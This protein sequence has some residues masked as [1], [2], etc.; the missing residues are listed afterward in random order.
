MDFSSTAF[1]TPAPKVSSDTMSHTNLVMS[2][3]W[4]WTST[5]DASTPSTPLQTRPL[6][7]ATS[8]PTPDSA[9]NH[10][11]TKRF[12][13]C[14]GRLYHQLLCSHRIR[15]DLVE[16]CGANCVEPYGSAI[17]VA[18]ICNECVDA[19][20]A[21]IHT[22][23]KAQFNAQFPP[24]DQMTKEQ[25]E[26]WYA[27]QAALEA[28]FERDFNS[29]LADLKAKTRP[30]NICSTIAASAEEA[31]FATELD[32]LSLSLQN[33]N[34]SIA[35]Q[36]QLPPR[37]A[38][39][40]VSL[41]YDASETLHWNLNTLDLDRGSCGIEYLPSPTTNGVPTLRQMEEEELWRTPRN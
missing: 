37:A 20:A 6:A 5:P 32:S 39:D 23:R 2:C 1:K 28:E 27:G 7:A 26:Q 18:F 40:R 3:R 31:E 38:R 41:P 34:T 21:K 36:P 15:T 13:P 30:S 35:D 8:R 14:H 11:R 25:Y 29:Y 12:A 22:E 17:G 24:M 9:F 10:L 16:D 33:S 4:G 19:E